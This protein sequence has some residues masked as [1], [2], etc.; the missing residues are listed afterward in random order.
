METTVFTR[1]IRD[2]VSEEAYR[3]FQLKL[4]SKPDSGNLIKGSGGLRKI[5]WQATGRGKRGGLRIIYYWYPHSS[6][7]YFL[8]VYQKNET[9]D[10]TADQISFLKSL[11]NKE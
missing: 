6:K 11:I 2:L 9:E 1:R 3:I 7:I 5:R 4:S 10:L 8:Y